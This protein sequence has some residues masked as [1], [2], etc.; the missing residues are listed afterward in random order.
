MPD[1]DRQ[2]HLAKLI[3]DWAW[4]HEDARPERNLAAP[5]HAIRLARELAGLMDTLETEQVALAALDTVVPD[6]YAEHWQA[7]L[8]FLS[9]LTKQWPRVLS[10]SGTLA[11]ADRRN[12]L[13]QAEAKR[14]RSGAHA[15]PMLIAGVTGSIPATADLMAA[16]AAKPNGA[17][18]LP[19]LDQSLDT[20]AFAAI[21]GG[22]AEADSPHPEHPQFGFAGLLPHLDIARGDVADVPGAAVPPA[23]RVRDRL[24]SEAMR[25][26]ATTA[27]WQ[28]FA[29]ATEAA[30][31]APALEGMSLIVTPT[32]QD[33]AEVA[34]LILRETLE[35]P[36]KTAALVSP[37]R[38]LA[39]RVA[40]RLKA[41]NIT[42]DDSA[43]RPLRKTPVGAF[44]DL[45]LE[46][47]DTEFA[48]VSVA[49]LLKHPMTRLGFARGEVR[50]HARN[51]ELAVFRQLYLGKGLDDLGI[52][53]EEA[54][55]ATHDDT[56][57]SRRF[58]IRQVA[59][60]SEA[61]WDGAGL[62]VA[63]M[64][65]ALEPLADL[66][67]RRETVP[68]PSL[69][70]T[71]VAAAE[72][73]A[74]PETPGAASPLWRREDGEAAADVLARLM[75]ADLTA[76]ELGARDLPTAFRALTATENVRT[77]GAVHPRLSIWGPVE[78]RL[79]RPDVV[80]L[81]SLN[82]G[83]WPQI[84]DTGPWLNRPMR[85]ELGLPQPE[86][87]TGRAA[88]DVAQ[89]M[90]A[91]QVYL[92]RAEKVDGTPTVPSRWLMRLQ[93]VVASTG[94]DASFA[95]KRP[96]L[97]WALARQSAPPRASV[98]QPKPCPPVAL[99]PRRLSVTD[100]GTWLMN[101]YALYAKKVLRL[102]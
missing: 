44:L 38:L 51:F 53:F 69:I 70:A 56:S 62:L 5:A 15:G 18:V 80:I 4:R 74:E 31:I 22:G 32:A 13:I 37:D 28:A 33:E 20:P 60:M 49:A 9:V 57:Q 54:R 14:V 11:P 78:A 83:T 75:V 7:T 39:R 77:R 95:P 89:L 99:R 46:A 25:P 82:E 64:T 100:V 36:G 94:A 76:P 52:A 35:T 24:V 90:G 85:R 67:Q 81:G 6:A 42:V 91:D 8:S 55:R 96:W 50:R 40:A 61:D 23:L 1:L 43:G 73:L 3:Q 16:V 41:W 93:A 34:A 88:H 10:A 63:R 2:L 86:E 97:A 29:E 102:D 79:Q 12:Q 21:R 26:A 19:G 45:I 98:V 68:L 65:K 17:I 71:F 87:A 72:A 58:T 59:L 47:L 84:P 66:A 92:T 101:P 48:P 27:E 30:A